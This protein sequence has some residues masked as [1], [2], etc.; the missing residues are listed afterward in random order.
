MRPP[1]SRSLCFAVVLLAACSDDALTKADPVHAVN[2]IV[3]QVTGPAND[4]LVTVAVVNTGNV[5]ALVPS[6]PGE[7]QAFQSGQWISKGLGDLPVNC[8]DTYVEIRPGGTRTWGLTPFAL[9]T[10][11]SVR[12]VSR[13]AFGGGGLV[14]DNLESF[15]SS[16]VVVP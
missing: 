1:A 16:P 2:P 10:G 15:T 12:F 8:V 6:C 11:A 3:V 14:P 5:S 7:V 4:R 9:P 13:A